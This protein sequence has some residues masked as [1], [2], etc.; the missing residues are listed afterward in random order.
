[1]WGPQL[2]SDWGNRYMSRI[3]KK[4]IIFDKE[5]KVS[6]V[7]NIVSIVGPKGKLDIVVPDD[8]DVLIADGSIEV[9]PKS[10]VASKSMH[11]LFR[12]L[13]QNAI[14]GVKQEWSKTLELV[15]VGFKV[16]GSGGNL[17][18][19]LGFSHPIKITAPVGITFQ[20]AENKITVR[21]ADKYLVG[22]VA[23]GIRR[24]KKPDPYKGK[25][26]RYLGEYI[27]KKV[28]KA[29]KTVGAATTK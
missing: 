20:V 1:M 27:R 4:P 28:G 17:T 25:G 11:G 24:L 8:I 16:E 23:A 21:G 26:I 13:L 6:K 10:A 19:S 7:N 22:E 5:I 29:A 9:K 18:L 14:A 12:S 2:R 3:G 15:G